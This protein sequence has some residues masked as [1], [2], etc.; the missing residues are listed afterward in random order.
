VR[1]VYRGLESA[2]HLPEFDIELP[3]AE[4]YDEVEFIPESE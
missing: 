3:L 1:E 4:V 2:I